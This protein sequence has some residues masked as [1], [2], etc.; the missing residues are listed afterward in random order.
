MSAGN[1]TYDLDGAIGRVRRML[2]ILAL[3]GFW[4]FV[5]ARGWGW[6][7]SFLAGALLAIGGFHLTHRFVMSIGPGGNEK[8]RF[9]HSVLL[10]ARYLILGGIVW[11]LLR[12]TGLEG[13]G[14]LCGLLTPA[15]AMMAESL[16]ELVVRN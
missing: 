7:A 4:A 6:G 12:L 1:S 5:L 9:W 14:V 15:A 11:L 13:V 8:P 2:W 16:R 10:G 3:L